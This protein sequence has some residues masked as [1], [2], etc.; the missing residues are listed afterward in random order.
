LPFN[1]PVKVVEPVPP[2]GTVKGL[3]RFRVF[4]F[5]DE[6]ALKNPLTIKLFETVE[7]AWEINPDRLANPPTF[8]VDE[9]DKGPETFKTLEMV[10]EAMESK[11]LDNWRTPVSR[12]RPASVRTPLFKTEKINC[13]L[14]V[15]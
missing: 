1:R 7:E 9:A 5:A 13:P 3:T 11:P 10:E 6:E 14:P 2:F 8:K 4:M 12:K 15:K